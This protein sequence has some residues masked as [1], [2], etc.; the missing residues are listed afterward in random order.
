ME[1][2]E[3]TRRVLSRQIWDAAKA[4]KDQEFYEL[5]MDYTDSILKMR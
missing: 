1:W 4:N 5:L 2:G 3:R